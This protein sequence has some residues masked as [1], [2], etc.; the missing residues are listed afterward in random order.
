LIAGLASV[1]ATLSQAI[2][3]AAANVKDT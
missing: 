3:D 1:T 2:C